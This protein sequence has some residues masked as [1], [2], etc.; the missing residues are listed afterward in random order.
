MPPASVVVAT[1]A[2]ATAGADRIALHHLVGFEIGE[3]EDAAGVGGGGD[4]RL[5]DAALVERRA[6]RLLHPAQG[7]GVGRVAQGVAGGERLAARKEVRPRRL[8]A[9]ELGRLRHR[10]RQPRR[11]LEAVLG[12]R[13]RRPEQLGPVGRAVA[14]VDHVEKLGRAR[15]PDRAAADQ[16]VPER[17][18]LAVHAREVVAVGRHRGG[19]AAVEGGELAARG[20]VVDQERAAAEPGGLRLDQPE[21]GLDGDHG[22]DRVAAVAQHL[23]AGL[24]GERMRRRHHALVRRRRCAQRDRGRRRDQPTP[25]DV[26]SR[27]W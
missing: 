9:V 17:Q 25:H 11:H 4:D 26:S 1:I 16:R 15:H 8:E 6:A 2:S 27:Y 18:R 19:L 24:G 7:G 10:A 14:G 22:V 5:G 23:D 21:H 3:R 20:V 12:E 13:D